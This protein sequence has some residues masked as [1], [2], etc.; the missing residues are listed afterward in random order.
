VVGSPY[1]GRATDI[2]RQGRLVV[3]RDSGLEVIAAADVRHV[4]QPNGL[5]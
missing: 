2:D 4:R 3:L 1:R 5:T